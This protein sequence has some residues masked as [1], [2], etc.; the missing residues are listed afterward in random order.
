MSKL[1]A[2]KQNDKEVEDNDWE[3]QQ[4]LLGFFSLLLK[5][6]KRVSP[7]LYKKDKIRS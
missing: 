2:E 5:V 1:P 3:A 4:N 6:D 7:Y